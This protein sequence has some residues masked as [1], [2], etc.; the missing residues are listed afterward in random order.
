[1]TDITITPVKTDT[2]LLLRVRGQSE[3]QAPYIALDLRSGWLRAEVDD[4]VG[5]GVPPE[6]FH[7][8]D[9]R[10]GIGVLRAATANALMR[11][12][13]P[14][15]QRA[16]DGSETVWDGNNDVAALDRDAAAAI[17]E[18][19]A[20]TSEYRKDEVCLWDPFDPLGAE[21]WVTAETVDSQFEG[22]AARVLE[23][24]AAS[25]EPGEVLV[26]CFSDSEL[27][28]LLTDARDELREAS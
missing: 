26:C 1:M 10:F 7:G 4:T 27:I 17:R 24:V 28:E 16:V 14:L 22:I 20:L 25:A 2:D 6:V 9:R 8:F 18:I 19:E 11:D 3:P 23:A 13:A 12:I 5:P 15:A 21:E